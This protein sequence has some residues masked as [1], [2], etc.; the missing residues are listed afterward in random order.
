MNAKYHML[1]YAE[2]AIETRVLVRC[3]ICH[4]TWYGIS[5]TRNQVPDLEIAVSLRP[6]TFHVQMNRT[7]MKPCCQLRNSSLFRVHAFRAAVSGHFS[8]APAPSRMT[9]H[10]GNAIDFERQ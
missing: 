9:E 2:L 6:R 10:N 3:S 8:K 7:Q 1:Y 4:V 5:C